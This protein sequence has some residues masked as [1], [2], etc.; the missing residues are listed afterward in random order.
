MIK[1]IVFDLDDTLFPE[2]EYV[3]SGFR[4]VDEWIA[5]NCFATGFFEKAVHFFNKGNRGNIF[6]LTLNFL[7]IPY[8]E[9]FITKLI[10]IY[11]EHKPRISLYD[12]AYW[13]INYYKQKKQLGIIT[14]GY[15]IT[16]KNKIQALKIESFFD[17]IIYSDEFGK[18]NWKPSQLPYLKMMESLGRSGNECIYIADN[19]DKDFIAPT[20]LGWKTVWINRNSGEYSHY[21]PKKGYG[22]KLRVSSLFELK[23]CQL[24]ER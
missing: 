17:T 2:K 8:D 19:P 7:G 16:Q 10:K 21:I 3:L 1:A 11:R 22:A 20:N 14:D 9:I 13:V 23:K 12:D 24:L 6:N 4:A 5:T 18:D 15:L